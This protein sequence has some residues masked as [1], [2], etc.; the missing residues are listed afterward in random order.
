VVND[1]GVIRHEL[2][3]YLLRAYSGSSP[4]WLTEGVATWVQYYPDRFDQLQVP[5]ALYD[6]L[7]HADRTLPTIGLFDTDP[8]ADY[9]ISQAAVAWLVQQ[10]GV[11]RLLDL[12][13]AYRTHYR[14]VNVDALTPRLLRQVY[15]VSEAQVVR[16]AFALLAELHH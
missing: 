3:H 11:S 9:P 1:P 4:K 13:R 12:M 6:R 7:T 10:D 8:G 5:A 14:D 16:G 15:G 2:T